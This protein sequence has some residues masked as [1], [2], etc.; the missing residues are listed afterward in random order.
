VVEELTGA[1]WFR[2]GFANSSPSSSDRLA[3][4]RG[5]GTVLPRLSATVLLSPVL[6]VGRDG[7]SPSLELDDAGGGLP[8]RDVGD[9]LG[10]VLRSSSSSG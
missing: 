9:G 6:T 5:F 2:R 8:M 10:D 1:V 3:G 4:L 7:N